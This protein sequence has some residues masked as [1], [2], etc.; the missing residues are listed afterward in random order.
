MTT[1]VPFV[2]G[3]GAGGRALVDRSPLPK[4]RFLDV[5]DEKTLAFFQLLNAGNARAYGGMGMP[6]WV[7]LDCATL[8]S[9][10]IGFAAPRADVDDDLFADLAR[11]ARATFGDAC[12]PV[13]ARAAGAGYDGL[14]PLSE[15][16]L[17]PSLEP[18]VVVGFS[19]F[20]L[21]PGLGLRSKALALC[22]HAP[23]AQ[24]GVAQWANAAVKT[25]ARLGDLAVVA[26]RAWAH[27]QP[28]ATFVYRLTPHD[29]ATLRALAAGAAS[30]GPAAS[31]R[32]VTVVSVADAAA[33]ATR[34]LAA[35]GR[36][37]IVAP[38]H[39]VDDGGR[40][41]TFGAGA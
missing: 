35:G 20:A 39:V 28:E 14:V 16:C 11:Y 27:S 31:T 1:L 7:Q 3:T 19:L 2:L 4:T 40:C 41:V 36:P 25:H 37:T 13:L 33:H 29:D 38:G 5:L 8:P 10:M 22:C 30:S 23:R 34:A 6:A 26:P 9:A 15:S 32:P 17:T 18:G 12:A 21:A 24:V